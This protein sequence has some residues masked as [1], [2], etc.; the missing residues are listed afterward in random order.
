[1]NDPF[2]KFYDSG[3]WGSLVLNVVSGAALLVA[4]AWFVNNLISTRDIDIPPRIVNSVVLEPTIMLPGHPF[5][6]HINVTLNK[7]CPYEVHWSLVRAT[8]NV[9]VVKVIEPI[10]QPPAETG[11]QE[12]PVVDRYIPSSTAPGDYQYV[13]E[14]Y[15]IC[16]KGHTFISVRKN[17]GVNIR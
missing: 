17:V 15:D 11:T 12:L 16:G 10:K 5:R 8:D 7:L 6:A 4:S 1:M 2:A 13:S 14:V 9:E 3:T